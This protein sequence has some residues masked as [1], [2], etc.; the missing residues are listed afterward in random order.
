MPFSVSLFLL[1]SCVMS[2]AAVSC[3][4]WCTVKLGG[5]VILMPCCFWMAVSF[6]GLAGLAASGCVVIS[7]SGA[8]FYSLRS[9]KWRRGGRG[10]RGESSRRVRRVMGAWGAAMGRVLLVIFHLVYTAV[11]QLVLVLTFTQ[12]ILVHGFMLVK[13]TFVGR[14]AHKPFIYCQ[15]DVFDD[16]RGWLDSVCMYS[17]TSFGLLYIS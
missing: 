11:L 10:W 6:L 1:Y 17:G 9:P 3:V 8:A 15:W 14:E 16:M 4:F 5:W 2:D 7:Q 12:R 13:Q